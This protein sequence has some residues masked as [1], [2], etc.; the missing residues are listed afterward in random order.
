MNVLTRH[1]D[2]S[3]INNTSINIDIKST[4]FN[5]THDR[6]KYNVSLVGAGPGGPN[7]LTLK[8][9]G[10]LQKADVVVFNNLVSPQILSLA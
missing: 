3:L 5:E 7:L 4:L 1:S 8:A 10:I 9:Y 6:A 2:C